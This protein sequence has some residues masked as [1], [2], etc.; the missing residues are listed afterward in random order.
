MFTC[1]SCG[2]TR[3]K[4]ITEKLGFE[5]CTE[6]EQRVYLILQHG[7]A[8]ARRQRQHPADQREIHSIVTVLGRHEFSLLRALMAATLLQL[9][10]GIATVCPGWI[11][12][13]AF[14]MASTS[15]NSSS[16]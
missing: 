9:D 8:F 3:N 6:C 15:S 2:Y 1:R 14:R 5:L 13:N 12:A 4:G 16:I 10:K 7:E 11:D